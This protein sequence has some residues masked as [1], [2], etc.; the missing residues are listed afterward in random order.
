MLNYTVCEV[1]F[2]DGKVKEYVTNVIAEN[3]LTR[4]NFE[5][6]TTTMIEEIINYDRDET[7][8]AHMK[9]KYVKTYSNQRRLRKSTAVWK[10]WVLWKDRTES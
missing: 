4:V 2:S 1:E 5:G 8:A 6:F 10:M 9:D 7:T 3:M